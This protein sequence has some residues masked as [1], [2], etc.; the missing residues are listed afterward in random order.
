MVQ[1]LHFPIKRVFCI[2]FA[3]TINTTAMRQIVCPVS[4]DKVDEKTTRINALIGILLVYNQFC[5]EFVNLF[6]CTDGRFFYCAL[7]RN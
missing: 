4:A 6:D 5:D 7:L 1:F 3:S 2:L